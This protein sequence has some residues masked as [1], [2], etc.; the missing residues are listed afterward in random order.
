MRDVY[1]VAFAA[2]FDGADNSVSFTASTKQAVTPYGNAKISAAQGKF[3]Q[4]AYF[5]GTTGT[6]LSCPSTDF[7]LPGDFW[8]EAWV[9][10]TSSATHFSVIDGRSVPWSY[11]NYVLGVMNVSGTMRLDIVNAGGAGTRLT[12]TSTSV[13]LN[14]LTHV[15]YGRSSGTLMAFVNGVK[16]ATTKSYSSAMTPAAATVRIGAIID[17]GYSFGY[18]DELIVFNYC[19]YTT[20]FTPPS[21]AFTYLLKQAKFS[22]IVNTENAREVARRATFPRDLLFGMKAWDGTK[23]VSW[24]ATDPTATPTTTTP[25]ATGP[26]VNVQ[27][28]AGG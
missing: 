14:T 2:H 4:S 7:N 8:V 15:A 25:T 6:Y 5:D 26:L 24:L 3:G 11:S 12:G 20:D 27:I 17:P 16:D 19:L 28:V 22:G 9:Y 18:I 23:W 10:I 21:E 1:H 13:P